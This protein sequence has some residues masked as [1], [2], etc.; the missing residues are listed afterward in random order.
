VNSKHR[1]TLTAIFERP[2][3]ASIVFADIEALFR[4]LG[5]TVSERAGARVKIELRANSSSALE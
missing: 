3:P 4:A 2:T 1:R 5:G